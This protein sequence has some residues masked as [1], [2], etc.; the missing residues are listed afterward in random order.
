LRT[1]QAKVQDKVDAITEIEQDIVDEV[2]DIDDKW[3]DIAAEIETLEVGLEKTDISIDGI[4]LVW[5]RK[6]APQ[7]G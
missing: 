2:A 1:A 4:A 7:P 3:E 6:Q 5:V